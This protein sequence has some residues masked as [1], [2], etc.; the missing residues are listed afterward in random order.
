MLDQKIFMLGSGAVAQCALPIILKE[1]PV[2]PNNITVMDFADNRHRIA[3][4]IKQGV[5][6]VQEKI[7]PENYADILKKYLSSG[8]I[9]V[10][11][12]WNTN[13]CD[14]LQWCRD[15]NVRFINASIELWDPYKDANTK[16]PQDLTLYA[17][18]MA[19]QRLLDSWGNNKGATAI[20]DHGANPGLVSHFTKQ[21]LVDISNKLIQEKPQDKRVHEI[22]SALERND[23]AKV[24]Q[25]L[26]VKTIHI[27]ER[28]SQ[29]ISDPKKMNEFVN[30]W[31]IPGLHEEGIAPSE[32]AW[33]THEKYV[34]EGA[35]FHDS[36]PR[37]QICLK[38]KGIDT[39][40]K[41][42]VPSG[43][44][45]G[46][47][48][49]HGE[50]FGISDRL[51]VWENNQPVY[52]PTVNYA[53]CINDPAIASLYELRMR[54]F[55]LQP[56]LRIMND[57]IIDG[58]DE[59]GCLLMGH[60]YKAWWIGSLLNIND[61]RKLVPHQNATTVQVA[62]A[63][64]AGIDYLIK[65]PNDGVCLP[66]DLNYKEILDFSKPYLGKFVSM[67]VDWSPLDIKSTYINY[68]S[69]FIDRSDPWQFVNFLTCR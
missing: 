8:D 45:I 21:A 4:A 47:V 36:G 65:H 6:F 62:I 32:I 42:W 67:P 39:L 14:F 35:M 52:R 51:T 49:R 27:S 46:M 69:C 64:A 31:S 50:T 48:I 16:S 11:L 59:L 17:R 68:E 1:L 33:G 12:G 41:S 2:D 24:A 57:E 19:I 43:E 40:V 66:D 3:D 13:T 10:D 58:T 37:N 44:I 25:L 9:F 54:Q 5:K 18:H 29:I 61:S 63:V 15:N 56:K 53:Y 38:L 22:K 23:F 7:T 30:T 20:L 26:G 28:D 34:P 60:D 55:E